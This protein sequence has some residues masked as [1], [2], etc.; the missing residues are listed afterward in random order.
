MEQLIL[1]FAQSHPIVAAILMIIGAIRTINKPLF[2]WLHKLAE[3]G[4]W[5]W[6]KRTTTAI[7]A[8]KWY[9]RFSY[10]L[11][12]MGSVKLEKNKTRHL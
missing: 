1:N 7:E 6:L 2:S 9:K 10:L 4:Q 12:W 11:D 5:Q 8:S 3:K